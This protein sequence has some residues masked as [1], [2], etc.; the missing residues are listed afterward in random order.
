MTFN[1]TSEKRKFDN[2]WAKLAQTYAEAGMTPEAIQEMYEYDWGMFKAARIEALHTQEFTIPE[3]THE[4]ASECESPLFERFQNCLS[5]GYDTLGTH[6]R[7]WWI[8][9]L[10]NPCI[11]I[12]IPFLTD[13]DKEILTLYVIEGYTENE[14]AKRLDT[15][16][17]KVSRRLQKIFNYFK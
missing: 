11:T 15:Y 2:V 16:Q 3:S 4:D 6:S 8:E 7:F 9:E 10:E 12:G 5:S 1:Y 13:E 14:I 17:V